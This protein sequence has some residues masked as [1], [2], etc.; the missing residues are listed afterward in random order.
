MVAKEYRT[1]HGPTPHGGVKTVIYLVSHSDLESD[2]GF[3]YEVVEFDKH[4]KEI[5]RTQG[6][7]GS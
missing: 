1:I 3:R 5:F 7:P 4:G 6:N 2:L